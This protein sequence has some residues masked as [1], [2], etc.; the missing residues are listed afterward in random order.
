MSRTVTK[1]H[2]HEQLVHFME[3]GST[4][5]GLNGTGLMR[6]PVPAKCWDKWSPVPF[7][8]AKCWD[9]WSPLPFIQQNVGNSGAQFHSKCREVVFW[10]ELNWDPLFPEIC[11]IEWN[12][13]P[14][15][16]A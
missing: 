5:P 3:L 12:W 13:A 2:V 16:P 11:C 15:F 4:F 7:I 9:K 10:I 6:S 14:H 1:V 8:P